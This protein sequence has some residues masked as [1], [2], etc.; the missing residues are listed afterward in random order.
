MPVRCKELGSSSEV[1]RFRVQF[2]D[3]LLVKRSVVSIAAQLLDLGRVCAP[4]GR[5]YTDEHP[6]VGAEPFQVV[7]A[8]RTRIDLRHKDVQPA[9]GQDF[10]VRS[11]PRA[12]CVHR[13]VGQPLFDR[14]NIRY[15]NN[16]AGPVLDADHDSAASR[17]RER[18]ESLQDAFVG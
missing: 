11:K 1:E 2:R 3:R 5:A 15:A 6:V 13:Q 7:G 16:P 18:D 12:D 4:V 9:P 10:Y 8:G 14:Q 17:V